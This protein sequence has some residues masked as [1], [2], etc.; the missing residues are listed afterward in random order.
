MTA[1]PTMGTMT[2]MGTASRTTMDEYD[3]HKRDIWNIVKNLSLI[4]G[5]RCRIKEINIKF[6]YENPLVFVATVF[7]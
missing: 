6:K 3:S 7:K 2:A 5:Q 1:T 4:Q